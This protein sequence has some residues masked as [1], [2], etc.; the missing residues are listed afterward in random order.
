MNCK[1]CNTEFQGETCPSCG[2]D[3]K[4][5]FCWDCFAMFYEDALTDGIC[6]RCLEK[7]KSM[8]KKNAI[9]ALILSLCP[10]FGLMYLGF[11]SKGFIY[12]AFFGLSIA[13]PILGW[14]LIPLTYL[15]PIADTI[16]TAG[17]LAGYQKH[18]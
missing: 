8:P 15:V 13:I 2:L 18:E 11:F 10:G 7:E 9:L 16:I 12:F 17:R 1:S 3:V 4:K 6:P 5:Q 14:I